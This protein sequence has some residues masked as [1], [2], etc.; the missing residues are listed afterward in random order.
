MAC[1]LVQGRAIDCRDAVGGVAEVYIAEFTNVDSVTDSSGT[2]TAISMASGSKYWIYRMEKE[3][4]SLVERETASVENG[5]IFY[6]Q[7]LTFTLKKMSASLRN[8]IKNLAQNRLSIIVKDNNGVYWLMGQVN[9]VDKVGT[10]EA[11]TGQAFGDLQGYTLT[12]MGKEGAPM[13]IV[14]TSLFPG[15]TTAAA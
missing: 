11:V 2:V 4:A 15:L 5:T 8:E 9:A 7:E 6:E 3:N 13:N 1:T 14:D 10:N 12:F